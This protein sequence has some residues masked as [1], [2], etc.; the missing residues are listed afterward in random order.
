MD[1]HRLGLKPILRKLWAARGQRPIVR[2]QHRYQWLY[3]WAFVNPQSGQ[4]V[5]YI[6]PTVSV[7]AYSCVLKNFAESV[8]A[9]EN[10]HIML[11][12]DQAGWHTSKRL[13]SPSGIELVDLPP[14]SPELQPAERLWRLTDE[15]LV[16]KTFDTLDQLQE[17]LSERCALLLTQPELLSSETLYHWWPRL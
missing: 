4:S 6:L 11:V 1:E 3:L 8:G 2:V 5:W 14:Y 16:N 7:E 9:S 15:P 10:K 13:E 12:Q 17:R